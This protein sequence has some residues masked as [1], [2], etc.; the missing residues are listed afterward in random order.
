MQGESIILDWKKKNFKPIYW[1]EGDEPFFIDQITEYAIENILNPSEKDFNCTILYGKDTSWKDVSYICKRFPVFAEKQ[2]VVIKEA[3]FIDDKIENLDHYLHNPNITTILIVAYKNK[4]IDGRSKT[5]KLI[6]DKYEYFNAK[7]L[8][9]NQVPGL[10]TSICV[11]LKVSINPKANALLFTYLGNDLNK[12]YNEIKKI[13][14]NLENRTEINENDIYTFIGM[15]R[16]YNV[17][18]LQDAIFKKD[19]IKIF[20]I[21]QYFENN[22]KNNPLIIILT[23][24]FN[25]FSKLYLLQNLSIK[26]DKTIASKLGI[27]SFFIKDYIV[28]YNNYKNNLAITKNLLL[29]H[30]YNLKMLGI[31]TTNTNEAELL[32]ELIYKMIID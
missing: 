4:K 22:P 1:L 26:D 9:D 11:E 32:K 13:L 12:I 18:E 31:G 15:S 27:N 6:K 19:K 14:I 5:A 29:L 24:L 8:Y 3:Q 23:T 20:N 10:I 21:L 30:D 7:K 2:L 17:F 25:A 16:E 28:G